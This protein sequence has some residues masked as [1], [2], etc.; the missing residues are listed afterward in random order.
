[1]EFAGVSD[2]MRKAYSGDM[3]EAAQQT[4]D[5][6]VRNNILM[7][8]LEKRKKE[9]E[10][11]MITLFSQEEITQDYIRDKVEEASKAATLQAQ[12]ASARAMLKDGKL[13]M[14]QITQYS[15][16]SAAEVKKLAEEMAG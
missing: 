8:F 4:I 2:R 7:P 11:I 12:I 15:G 5:Y 14:E 3:T 9:V 10:D 1:M 13:S 16:L 6:C